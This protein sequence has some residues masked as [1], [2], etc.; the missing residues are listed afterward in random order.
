ME[1]GWTGWDQKNLLVT[2]GWKTKID[3]SYDDFK[4]VSRYLNIFAYFPRIIE[5]KDKWL[6]GKVIG[7]RTFK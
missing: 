7:D 5:T 1:L 4:V 2:G 6:C 3:L